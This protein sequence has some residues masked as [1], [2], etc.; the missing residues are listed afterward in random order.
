M[1]MDELSNGRHLVTAKA[2]VRGQRHGR[3]D[4]S[5][6]ALRHRFEQRLLRFLI[7]FEGF[8]C[9]RCKN[10][11]GRTFRQFSVD[12]D[13]AVDYLAACDSHRGILAS[14]WEGGGMDLDP[15]D[16]DSR[17]DERDSLD[18][19]RGHERGHVYDPRDRGYT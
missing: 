4:L 6:P 8:L 14:N 7:G 15:R 11:Y 1:L 10:R 18:R 17:D 16:S 2:A 3:R 9:L 12:L 5:S 19:G 13:A